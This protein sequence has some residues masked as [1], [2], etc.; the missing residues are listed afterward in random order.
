MSPHTRTDLEK[1]RDAR[2]G[3]APSYLSDS[4]NV[5][6]EMK[7]TLGTDE[8]H[9]KAQKDN[10][11]ALGLDREDKAERSMLR[12]EFYRLL[13][14]Q[15]LEIFPLMQERFP[16]RWAPRYWDWHLRQPQIQNLLLGSSPELHKIASRLAR[17]NSHVFPLE[18]TYRLPIRPKGAFDPVTDDLVA[19]GV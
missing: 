10:E 3:D 2:K 11:A 14:K 16:E 17:L 12:T 19:E 13:E 9:R 5:E 7:A 8:A 6:R 15:A 18:S 4:K 1:A